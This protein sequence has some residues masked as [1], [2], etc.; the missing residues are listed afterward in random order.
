MA[1]FG[2]FH[3]SAVPRPAGDAGTGLFA[4]STIKMGKNV[5]SIP[6]TFSTVLSTERLGDACSGCFSNL[7]FGANVMAS[8]DMKLR[9]CSGCKV[10]KYCSK[11]CQAENWALIHKHEC[12]IYKKL[13]PKI[14]PVN[15]RAVLRIVKLRNSK[16]ADV[17]SDMTMFLG[18]RSHLKEIASSNQEQYERIM[19][20]AKAEKEYSG[21]GLDLE[22]IAEYL[23][24]IEVNSFTF[25]TSF[26]DPLGLCIQPFACYMNH[27]CDPNAVV[28]FDE[29]LITV[30]ALRKIKPDEQVFISYIDNTYPFEV[31]QKQL[32]ERY[33]FTCKCS[34]CVEGVTA[35]EDQFISP[36]PSSEEVETLKEAEKQARE[37]LTT[38]KS[39]KGESAIK[40]LKGALK[41][42]HDTKMWPITRQPY[43]EIRS[44]LIVSL[45][46]IEDFWSAFRHSA[47]RYLFVDQILYPHEWHPIRTN[48]EFVFSQLVMTLVNRHAGLIPNESKYHFDQV[49]IIYP[50]LA[51]LNK[52]LKY[53]LPSVVRA[54][55]E[56]YE[57]LIAPVKEIGYD[58]S[59]P[60]AAK[61]MA[62]EWKIVE[63]IAEETLEIDG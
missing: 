18:L 2:E 17:Q 58:P 6:V 31:R 23:A 42:L 7:P 37:F 26:G 22:T 48:H 35:R 60:S 56:E 32:A 39:S 16:D 20:C 12:A 49:S 46:D 13:Y 25:T 40:Q 9:A 10:V 61:A 52:H 43:P 53:E 34:K 33:F 50:V 24:R 55:Q 4:T 11:G 29:G 44:E 30:K 59:T 1:S 27:S 36:N 62:P 5:F 38:A 45:L 63:G 57:S 8:V 3:S 54:Y 19:L 21:S 51:K 14:L 41:V 28:G 15:S 47:V